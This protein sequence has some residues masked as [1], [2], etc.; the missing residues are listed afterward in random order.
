MDVIVRGLL[1]LAYMSRGLILENLAGEMAYNSQHNFT[2]FA[3]EL[4]IVPV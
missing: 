1:K 2:L 3:L 4:K